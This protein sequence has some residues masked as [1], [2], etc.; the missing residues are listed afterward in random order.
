MA[1][2]P[3]VNALGSMSNASPEE[4]VRE[5]TLKIPCCLAEVV[6]LVPKGLPFTPMIIGPVIIFRP[7][8]VHCLFEHV[9]VP[10]LRIQFVHVAYDVNFAIL[11]IPI[12]DWNCDD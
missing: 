8:C 12:S 1:G 11:L 10:S 9:S 3:R 6:L 5:P 7:I 2:T 4:R